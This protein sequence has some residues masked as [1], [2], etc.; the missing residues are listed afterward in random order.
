MV[1]LALFQLY[2]SARTRVVLE[3]W[4][5]PELVPLLR[6]EFALGCLLPSAIFLVLCVLSPT[7][8]TLVCVAV[9]ILLTHAGYELVEET[10]YKGVGRAKKVHGTEHF[11]K[12]KLGRIVSVD[13]E[14]EEI[15][16]RE[17]GP[18]I[19]QILI[20]PGKDPI[21]PGLSR[22]RS[23]VL[24]IMLGS[25]VLALSA[26]ADVFLYEKLHTT[27]EEQHDH[28]ANKDHEA[29]QGSVHSSGAANSGSSEGERVEAG[30][31]DCRFQPGDGAPAW[32]KADLYALY[33][34]GLEAEVTKPPGTDIGGC[35]GLA[36]VPPGLKNEFVYA[37]GR[38]VDG[39]LRSVALVSTKYGPAIFLA[40]AAQ[41]VLELLEK[42]VMPIGGY[43]TED[44]LRG[45]IAPIL[46]PDGTVVLARA[47][48][49]LPGNERYATP[50]VKLEPTA[51]AA[52]V[53]VM[54]EEGM[55]LWPLGPRSV[56]GLQVFDLSRDAAGHDIA[57][58]VTFDPE[59]GVAKRDIYTYELPQP[60]ISLPDLR[61]PG[62]ARDPL[63]VTCVCV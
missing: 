2:N 14:L 32:A 29:D 16:K 60:Q 46:T 56:D 54:R 59:S 26:S 47:E 1:P 40:P 57:A 5:V 18:G 13:E 23:V 33:F 3:H 58:S 25:L 9:T 31:D 15:S 20:W 43:P 6:W 21:R 4:Q 7:S 38:N 11:R 44:V 34:G 27:Q 37:I 50:Y 63:V 19:W 48:K 10:I 30:Q 45:D 41:Q 55:W 36:I 39:E 35:V 53:G 49:H 42:G 62:R 61:E 24:T 8:L 52:W 12:R 22:T 28:T 51:A 17:H